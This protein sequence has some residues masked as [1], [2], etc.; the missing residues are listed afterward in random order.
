MACT[1]ALLRHTFGRD[2]GGLANAYFD[3][4]NDHL[5]AHA[6][7][8][9]YERC[10][11]IGADSSN[12]LSGAIFG[13]WPELARLAILFGVSSEYVVYE[14]FR[15]GRRIIARCIIEDM[16]Q[17]DDIALESV[18]W[19]RCLTYA[20]A[21]HRGMLNLAITY[22]SSWCSYCNQNALQHV[23]MPVR[24]PWIKKEY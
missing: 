18:N 14:A 20:C 24:R 2:L 16:H 23:N 7:S 22:G 17:R 4:P 12:V 1:L 9:R 3:D 5:E 6:A 21:Y 11:V 19:N 15:T 10:N 13:D 8:G